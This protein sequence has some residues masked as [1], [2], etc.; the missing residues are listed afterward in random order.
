MMEQIQKIYESHKSK[1]SDINEHLETIFQI[2]KECSH[3]TEMGVRWVSSSWPM[4]LSKPKKM[5]SYDIVYNP[6][7][8][9]VINQAKLNNI[10]Y[11]FVQA[12]VLEIDIEPT[13][14]LFIDTLHTYNQLINE[15]N[16][17]AIKASKYV[18]LHDTEHFGRIDEKIYNHA[19]GKVKI[20]P[21]T[22]EGLMTAIEDFINS[23]NGK[24]WE[25][26]EIFTNNNGLTILKNKNYQKN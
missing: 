17:H 8:N 11:S 9:E 22:K 10:D 2:S 1:A 20:Q 15:L 12:D 13:E 7:I 26:F 18:I 14:L 23:E 5:I 16:K 19:S 4:L 3:I 25:I 6:N 24:L 21:K